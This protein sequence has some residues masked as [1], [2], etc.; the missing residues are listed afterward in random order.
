MRRL[1]PLAVALLLAVGLAGC[2]QNEVVINVNP[3]GSGT[4]VETFVLTPLALE[5][6]RSMQAQFSEDGEEFSL[7]DKDELIEQAAQ[8]G[9][10]V[11]FVSAEPLKTDAGE[12]YVAT[13]AF[14]DVTKLDVKM[15][16]AGGDSAPMGA[17]D[18]GPGLR[19]DFTP[20]DPASLSIRVP[21]EEAMADAAE[22]SGMA[23]EMAG[24]D[25][26]QA[27]MAMEMMRAML[28]G[29]HIRVAVAPQGTI[30]STDATY[31]EDGRIVLLDVTGDILLG[32]SDVLQQLSATQD[33]VAARALIADVPGLKVET[34]E[35]VSVSFE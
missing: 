11:R 14:D 29:M 24:A 25:S 16:Q 7:I 20:G 21:Q 5:Q 26:A 35:E 34:Q 32:D 18:D 9:G 17:S 19:F 1:A 33:P 31:R 12:G 27:E 3:D 2:F 15:D 6:M 13:Y 30:A 28:D 8:Y 10:G 22:E 4:I 23:D